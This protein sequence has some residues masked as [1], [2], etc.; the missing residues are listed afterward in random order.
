M[1]RTFNSWVVLD[2]KTDTIVTDLSWSKDDAEFR[3][4]TLNEDSNEIKRFVPA[5]LSWD[6]ETV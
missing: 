3:A 6:V 4:N 5:K 2:T 1:I